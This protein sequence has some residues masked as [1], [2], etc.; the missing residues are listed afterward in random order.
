MM[1][2][3]HVL[4]HR[5]SRAT[6]VFPVF[7]LGRKRRPEKL[8]GDQTSVAMVGSAM[9]MQNILTQQPAEKLIRSVFSFLL[10]IVADVERFD[11]R[12][13]SGLRL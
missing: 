12:R 1:T 9:L 8:F 10:F 4:A 7:M 5:L 2:A 11:S 3:A 13:F 6:L